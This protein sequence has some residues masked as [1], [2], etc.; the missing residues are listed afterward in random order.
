[1]SQKSHLY[2]RNS[3]EGLV[4]YKHR[5]G[6][7]GGEEEKTEK[8]YTLMAE[9][10]SKAKNK[11]YSD[12]EIR[13]NSRT[14]DIPEH[15]DLIEIT[16]QGYFNQPKYEQ[17]YFNEFGLLLL[18][19]SDYN[20][21]GLFAIEDEQKFRNFIKQIEIFISNTVNEQQKEFNYKI[22]YIKDFKLFS[23]SDMFGNISDY[24]VIHITFLQNGL[25]EKS[26]IKPQKKALEKFLIEKEIKSKTISGGI[27]IYH[28]NKN[29]VNTIFDNFDIIYASC[30]GSGVIVEPSKYNIPKRT[31]GFEII[32]ADDEDL[33]I[34]GIID[35][36][37]SNQTPLAPI[38]INAGNSYDLTA[39]G[40]LI[41]N[42][43]HGTGVAAFAAL[44]N[45]VI[46]DYRGSFEADARILPIKIMDTRNGAISQSSVIELIRKANK[47]FG[48]KIFTLSIGYA[49]FPLKNNEEFSL[50]AK[51]LDEITNEL[52]ILIF[53]STTN[54]NNIT[55]SCKYPDKFLEINSNIASPAESMNNIT[56]GAIA[57]NFEIIDNS[58]RRSPFPNF[59]AIYSRKFH[60][61]FDD[62][63]LFNQATR[64]K[65]LC[66][67][68]IL[69][70]GG[71]Y[72]KISLGF[73][74]GGEA[75]LE[76]LSADLKER[77]YRAVGT[78]FS[79]PFAAN[80]AAKILRKYPKLDMQTVKALIINSS[81]LP[82]TGNFFN[83]LSNNHIRRIFGNG[84]PNIETVLYSS[85][86]KVT[87]VMEDEIYPGY[88]KSY[89]L[90][91]P[92]YLSEA[93]RKNGVLTFNATLCF[94]F[95][96]KGN[97]Q[98]LY[99]PLHLAFAIGKNLELSSSHKGAKLKNGKNVVIDVQDGYNGNGSG[100]IKLNSSGG[101]SQDLYYSAKIVSNTQ[102]IN[103]NVSKENI[104]DEKNCFKIA[105]NSD[106]H[107]LLTDADKEPYNIAIPYS[108][109]VTIEQNPI[110]GEVLDDLYESL[111]AINRLEQITDIDLEATIR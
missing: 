96:P 50:Y 22:T 92:E 67:P 19:L 65:H 95:Q 59:P 25:I 71:D 99:C 63:R 21:K 34:I 8:D 13:H 89:P 93:K 111:I 106:F 109:V 66:K 81:Y 69:M 38:I 35:T 32:N 47:E 83:K 103:F 24:D 75:S 33:P 74:T 7:G 45:S 42:V 62:D 70:H 14:I 105:I 82:Q 84:I 16:F 85:E 77:T 76:I 58:I 41:D 31:F 40:A 1:M 54:T 4:K 53:I 5:S 17:S 36:G 15:F 108:L 12:I 79:A 86:N 2:F 56:I 44:G 102:K 87:F 64:N 28:S 97:N 23:S 90:Q 68:D 110:K 101:W 60:I 80:L 20:Q 55:D 94:K 107:K 3:D 9:N 48:V 10:F 98:L 100:A 57:D 61:N 6:G 104:I 52:D 73:V 91:L 11:L 37:V 29:F 78:S 30:S 88:I 51:M 49:D 39:T 18:H 72:Q 26:H 27:E 46:P 43:D